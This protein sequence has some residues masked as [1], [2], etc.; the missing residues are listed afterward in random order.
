MS[1][2]D[3][4]RLITRKAS[5][6]AAESE[7]T[8]VMGASGASARDRQE[9]DHTRL[10]RPSRTKQPATSLAKDAPEQESDDEVNDPVVGW[11]VIVEGPGKGHSLKLGFGMNSIGRAP[12]ERV[13]VDFGDSEISRKSHSMVTY[14][15]RGCKFYLQHGEGTNLTYLGDAPVLQPTELKGGEVIGIGNT[16]FAFVPFCGPNFNW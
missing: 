3:R 15:P 1:D 6:S 2:D 14:D 11:L 9:D 5:A 16:R 4:T 8:M 10:F 7:A 13:P 12:D